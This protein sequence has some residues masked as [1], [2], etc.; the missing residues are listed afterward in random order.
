MKQLRARDYSRVSHKDKERGISIDIQ[1]E[2]NA[3][4][5][6][7]EGWRLTG[8]Y[9]DDGISAYSD[10]VDARPQFAQM[11]QLNKSIYI[12]RS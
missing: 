4:C 11:L 6:A 1:R 9:C 3:E 8:H 5:A 12:I 10:Q 2:V 7:R